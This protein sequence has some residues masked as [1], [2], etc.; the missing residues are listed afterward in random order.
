MFRAID[1]LYRQLGKIFQQRFSCDTF[2][3]ECPEEMN[4]FADEAEQIFDAFDIGLRTLNM[5]NITLHRVPYAALEWGETTD[6]NPYRMPESYKYNLIIPLVLIT[7]FGTMPKDGQFNLVFRPE[8]ARGNFTDAHLEPGIGE[9]VLKVG[10]F[11]WQQY[12]TGR[13]SDLNFV[14]PPRDFQVDVDV[15]ASQVVASFFSP[16]GGASE[17]FG[18]EHQLGD[19]AVWESVS[20]PTVAGQI[21]FDII[22][23]STHPSALTLVR[24]L[25]G[26]ESVKISIRTVDV[27]GNRSVPVSVLISKVGSPFR[28]AG[29]PILWDYT[30]IDF[31]Q[32]IYNPYLARVD[33][34]LLQHLREIGQKGLYRAAELDLIFEIEER[35]IT[36]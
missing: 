12:H 7:R 34:P 36:L 23:D 3:R 32:Q 28:P 2:K 16:E 27:Y 21:E 22:S 14:Y 20:S 15:S 9:L 1:P 33:T 4:P 17:I 8:D 13:F 26:D 24:Q 10:G 25:A 35:K 19:G 30:I 31:T 11:F 5:Q 18:F 29:T 6:V